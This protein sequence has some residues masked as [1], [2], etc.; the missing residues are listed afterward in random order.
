MLNK[1]IA[2]LALEASVEYYASPEWTFT[3]SELQR[4]AESIIQR[5]IHELEVY[6]VPVGN[7]ASGELACEWTLDALRDVR[8]NIKEVFDMKADT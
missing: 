2:D 8:D 6:R 1:T 3:D 4:F 7:S 5:C